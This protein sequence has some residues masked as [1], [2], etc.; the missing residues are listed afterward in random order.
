MTRIRSL[1]RDFIG[2]LVRAAG[3]ARARDLHDLSVMSAQTDVPFR[4][5][6]RVLIHARVWVYDRICG[7]INC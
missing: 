2:R 4:W 1:Y 6:E 3:I 5:H 7:P